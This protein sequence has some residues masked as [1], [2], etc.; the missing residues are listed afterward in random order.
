MTRMT[1]LLSTQPQEKRTDF[2]LRCQLNSGSGEEDI[3]ETEVQFFLNI[4]IDRMEII[5]AW[6]NV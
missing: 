1:L 3:M 6:H 4:H 2:P 5:S